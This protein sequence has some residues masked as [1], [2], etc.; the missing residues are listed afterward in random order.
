ME[1]VTDLIIQR[2]Q[3]E[4]MLGRSLETNL[5]NE[6]L[7][8]AQAI[9]ESA[10]KK[11]KG[12]NYKY[13]KMPE[14]IEAS[15]PALTANGL[16]IQQPFAKKDDQWVLRTILAHSSGQWIASE[17]PI[18]QVEDSKRS[19]EQSIGSWITYFRRY[20]YISI[21]CMNI[22]DESDNDGHRHAKVEE[23]V[24][25]YIS[26]KQVKLLEV[27]LRAFPH[28][29]QTLKDKYNIT[30]RH[31]IKRRDFNALLSEFPQ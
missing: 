28:I 11:T 13:A 4:I 23:S 9:M 17:Y 18:V 20:A 31:E 14:I 3:S 5:L 8:K 7:C 24:D 6:A 10:E 22:D 1:A 21:I 15:R 2:A 26:E 27:K 25:E 29:A 30:N 16:S 19:L 12:Y